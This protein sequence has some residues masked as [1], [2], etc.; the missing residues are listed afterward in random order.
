M[1]RTISQRFIMISFLIVLVTSVGL[2]A[3]NKQIVQDDPNSLAK[4]SARPDKAFFVHGTGNMWSSVTNYGSIGD[5]NGTSTGRPSM[6]WPGGSASDYLYDSGIWVGTRISG[7]A[8]VTSYFYNPDVEY[9]PTTGYPGELGTFVNGAKSKSLEDSYM[10]FDDFSDHAES[11][12]IPLGIKIEQRGMTWS[13]PEVDDIVAVEFEVINNGLNGDLEDVYIAF[14]YDVDVATVDATNHHIDDLVDY[15]GWD[16]ADS[17]TDISDS[18]DPYDLN[19]DGWTGYD[20]FGVPYDRDQGHNPN[21]DAAL[22]E[23]D[24]FFDEWGIIF[25][26]SAP[27]LKWQAD[28]D[29]LN[30]VA[31]Q[32]AI[33]DGDTLRGYI[34]PRSLSYIYDADDPV[35]SSNDY[36]EREMTP[37]ADGWFGGMITATGAAPVT[38]EDQQ[39][40]IASSHQWWNWESD[41]KTDADRLD[42]MTGNHVSSQAKKFLNNPLELGFPQFDYRFLITTGPVDIPDGGSAKLVFTAVIG[43]GLQGMRENADNTIA[44][45]YSGSKNSNPQNQSNWDEDEHWV[46]PIPPVVPQLSYSPVDNGVSLAWD[47]SAEITPDPILERPDF[48]GYQVYRALY[49]PNGWEMI[50]AFDNLENTPVYVVTANG[51][52]INEK[53]NGEWVM[54]DLPA[55]QNSYLDLGGNTVWGS[56]VSAP[57]NSIPY[58]YAISAHDPAKSASAAGQALPKAYSPLSN[59][60]KT[61]SGAFQPVYPGEQYRAGSAIPSLDNVQIVPNP[62]LG[63][64]RWEALYEDRLKIAGLP[65]VAKITILSLTGNMIIEILH[66]NGT[67]YEFWDLVSRN[68]QSVVSGLYLYV[69]EAPDVQTVGEA[70]DEIVKKVGKFAIFR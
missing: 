15:D 62:Y 8:V 25:D 20:E 31:G 24:G 67:D 7:E 42:Y 36:G 52:T 44:A 5:P 59:Y 54:V 39:Y 37:Q 69:V 2:F 40:G 9:L 64:A 34:F 12:H 10:V 60:R 27:V 19:G 70:S 57:I 30:R 58:F 68:N 45:Y 21:Y 14:W 23:A 66:D 51:D 48:E 32:P 61:P 22:S 47:Q 4:P 6:Q 11:S 18:V 50:A 16:D 35:S 46:L 53:V 28:V 65:P 41:P 56:T 1:M 43:K 13:L 17:D 3:R 55:I 63:T 29:V 33:V 38:I 26:E 49:N